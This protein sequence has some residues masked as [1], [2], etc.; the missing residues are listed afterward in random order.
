ME[1]PGLHF[2]D[3]EIRGAKE[4]INPVFGLTAEDDWP[5]INGQTLEI[6]FDHLI[7]TVSFPF[8][9]EFAMPDREK[10]GENITII[11]VHNI[12]DPDTTEDL[13]AYGLVCEAA[14]DR[15][16]FKVPLSEIVI[17]QDDPNYR[18]I[19]DYCVWYWE[20]KQS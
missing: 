12:V 13:E 9:A 15:G 6:I 1:D 20:V 11:E 7:S 2:Y 10:G 8:N 3:R 14:D 18:L 19:E 4:R 16:N 5:D 17:Q